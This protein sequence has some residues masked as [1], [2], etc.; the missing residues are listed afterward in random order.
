MSNIVIRKLIRPAALF[1]LQILTGINLFSQVQENLIDSLT[2]K[3]EN[4]VSAVP[5]EEIYLHTDREEYIA[6]EYIWTNFYIFERQSLKPSK[7]S[8]I[9]YIELLNS[10]NRP[11]VQKRFFINNGSGPGQL[12]LPDTLSTGNYSLRAYTN[13]MKNFLPHNCFVKDIRVYNALKSNK[14]VQNNRSEVSEANETK[15]PEKTGVSIDLISGDRE[16]GDLEI[17]LNADDNYTRRNDNLFYFFIQTHGKID[18]VRS[19]RFVDNKATIL[20][21]EN[22][23]APGINQITVFDSKGQPVCVNYNYSPSVE[24][25][26][27]AVSISSAESY[28]TRERIILD[29]N[30]GIAASGIS[31]TGNLSVSVIPRSANT[32]GI[33]LNDYLLFGTEFG[34]FK[35]GFSGIHDLSSVQIDSILQNIRSR[36]INWDLVLSKQIPGFKYPAETGEHLLSG[37]LSNDDQISIPESETVLLIM[38]GRE[39]EFQYAKTDKNGDFNFRLN[40]DEDIKDL[41]IMPDDVRKKK[42]IMLGSPFSD[43]YIKR[44]IPVKSGREAFPDIIEEWNVNYQT[45]KIY[46]IAEAGNPLQSKITRLRPVRFYGKPDI[47][48]ILA[49]YVS[50]PKMEEVFFELLPR[51]SL[52]KR[53]SVFEILI[54]ERFNENTFQLSPDLFLDGVKITDAAIIANLDPQDVE[55]I[56][57]VKDK[58]AIGTYFFPGIVNVVTKSADFRS[59]PLPDHMIRLPY[60]V[61]DPV[62]SFA[63]PDYSSE[64][65]RISSVPDFRNTLYWNPSLKPDKE[66]KVVAEFWTSDVVWEYE[67]NVQGINGEGEIISVRKFFSVK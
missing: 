43:K 28:S 47:E 16:K 34:P 2:R 22:T 13:W 63:M 41:V 56:D 9:A 14:Y 24:P 23:L 11:V 8:K 6:G 42:K 30:T 45:R 29:I 20:I 44:A 32:S 46:E 35:T 62:L 64:D 1:I 19:D 48:L 15:M 26:S 59:I 66:G 33:S 37:N 21:P 60:R 53:D 49:D 57:V 10:E 5:W 50:L 7:R 27:T 31:N 25:E 52:K 65:R 55:K 54:T 17:V 12:Q 40:I 38:P 18:L 58:Y 39:P 3:F 4:Y 51:V 67:I 61:I 36:W